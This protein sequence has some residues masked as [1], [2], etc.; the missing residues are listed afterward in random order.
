MSS[1]VLVFLFKK[2]EE[3]MHVRKMN[4]MKQENE[5]RHNLFYTIIFD[6][7]LFV[8]KQKLNIFG[9]YIFL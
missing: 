8:F 4:K 5:K 2:N 6:I 1:L 7:I 9:P 3:I